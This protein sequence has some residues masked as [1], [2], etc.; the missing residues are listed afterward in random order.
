VIDPDQY[1]TA[2][3]NKDLMRVYCG[4]RIVGQ[5]RRGLDKKWYPELPAENF[6]AAALHSVI[7]AHQ[8]IDEFVRPLTEYL[9]DD[10]GDR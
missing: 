5:L 8:A 4:E 9:E 1:R 2:H 3:I 10:D 6:K 7:I